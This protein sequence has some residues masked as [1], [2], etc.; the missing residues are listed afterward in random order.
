MSGDI[1]ISPVYKP[2]AGL[3]SANGCVNPSMVFL[4]LHLCLHANGCGSLQLL[5]TG[6]PS[7]LS[8]ERGRGGEWRLIEELRLTELGENPFSV[9]AARY[10]EGEGGSGGKLDVV[11]MVLGSLHTPRSRD[12]ASKPPVAHYYWHRVTLG[13]ATATLIADT[14]SV[15]MA[16][17]TTDTDRKLGCDSTNIHL[18]CSL[19]SQTIPLYTA[20]VGDRFL[21]I[22]EAGLVPPQAPSEEKKVAE[23]QEKEEKL[24]E[25]KEVSAD[26]SKMETDEKEDEEKEERES[27]QHKGLGF[28][29]VEPPSDSERKYKWSQTDSNVTVVVSLPD[30]VTKKDIECVIERREVVIGLSDGTTYVR[31]RLFGPVDPDSSTWT[32]ENHTWVFGMI[33]FL[34]T[35]NAQYNVFIGFI[36][37]Y[38][39]MFVY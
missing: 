10:V 11:T 23:E 28:K 24:G 4:S 34:Y 1:D 29:A 21:V 13:S 18:C 8:P 17:D 35:I 3:V 7:P 30:D 5:H 39:G 22:S 2:A 38:S 31:G 15:S 32:I 27:G 26:E 36:C 37:R 25:E 19:H 12:A 16:T 14:R 9:L 33:T 20:L 6:S